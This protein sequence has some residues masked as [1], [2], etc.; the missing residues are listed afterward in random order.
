[1]DDVVRYM[2]RAYALAIDAGRKDLQT[3]AAQVLAQTHIV[4]LELDEAELL[5][6]R[7]LELAGESGS[8]RARAARRS[9]TAG[10]SRSRA[11]SMPP[12][13]CYEEVRAD[14]GRA[15]R[16]AAVAVALCAGS[17][18]RR[19]RGDYKRAEKLLSRGASHHR[20]PGATAACCPTSRPSLADD[21]RR[22]SGKVDEAERLALEVQ[23][24][25]AARRSAPRRS[26]STACTGGR[27][28]CP[29]S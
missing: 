14:G 9:R 21:A 20:R 19:R 24:S 4:R 27:A 6:T 12:R 23:A 7:A 13:R 5:L 3:I 2:E 1:M 10:S 26:P 25:A 29:G 16:R 8:V 15:R 22:R 11:S 28:C 17:V 18:G